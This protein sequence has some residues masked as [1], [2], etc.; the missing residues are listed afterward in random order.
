[1]SRKLSQAGIEIIQRKSKVDR[2]LIRKVYKLREQGFSYQKIADLF[3]L[4]GIETKWYSKT[5]KI[6]L[7]KPVNFKP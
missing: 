4:W 2:A 5:V 3:N 6:F 1:V 7:N